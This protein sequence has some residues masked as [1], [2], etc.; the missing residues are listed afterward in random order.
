VPL[1]RAGVLHAWTRTRDLKRVPR[2]S[3]RA[4]WRRR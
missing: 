4:G 1:A 3:F 2:T